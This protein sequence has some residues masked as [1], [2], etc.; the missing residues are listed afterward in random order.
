LRLSQA[1][2]IE[3][4]QKQRPLILADDI[5][6]EIDAPTQ[7]QL[8]QYFRRQEQVSWQPQTA[9]GSRMEQP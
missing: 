8:L 1:E 9:S 3:Q 7:V 4:E 5:F 6:A 2:I